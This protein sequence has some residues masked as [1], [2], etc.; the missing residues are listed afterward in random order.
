M[1]F[2]IQRICSRNIDI[3]CIYIYTYYGFYHVSI[4][5]GTV[6]I[7]NFQRNIIT[8]S[9]CTKCAKQFLHLKVFVIY[10]L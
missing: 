2:S 10:Y 6:K 5:L 7:K 9:Y 1:E 4:P 3:K 8:L